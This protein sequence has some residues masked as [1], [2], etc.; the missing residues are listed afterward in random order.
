MVPVW[1]GTAEPAAGSGLRTT[2][3]V[4]FA[5]SN[6]TWSGLVLG[7]LYLKS[8]LMLKLYYILGNFVV[9]KIAINVAIKSFSLHQNFQVMVRVGSNIFITQHNIACQPSLFMSQKYVVL[10][11]IFFVFKSVF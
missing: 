4:R 2:I 1:F 5:D 9:R 6:R 11:T 8:Y 3:P 10:R 7:L